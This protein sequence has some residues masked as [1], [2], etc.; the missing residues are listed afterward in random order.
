MKGNLIFGIV[1]KNEPES[2]ARL[3]CPLDKE[4][5]GLV[6]GAMHGLLALPRAP[7]PRRAFLL[8]LFPPAQGAPQKFLTPPRVLPK[9][10]TPRVRFT[11]T[12]PNGLSARH[13]TQVTSPAQGTPHKSPATRIRTGQRGF[14]HTKAVPPRNGPAPPT[15]HIL[16]T[17]NGTPAFG[18][19]S[20][21][22]QVA[23]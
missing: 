3:R 14:R 20:V 17:K 23:T 15:T 22:V 8:T 1:A 6:S 9:F 16:T 2:A 10:T 4:R 19:R 7:A 5:A 11:P 12:A 21:N 18:R 13:N